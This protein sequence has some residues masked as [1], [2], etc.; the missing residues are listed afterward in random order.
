MT[1]LLLGLAGPDGLDVQLDVFHGDRH[2]THL[3]QVTPAADGTWVRKLT[4][5]VEGVEGAL[6]TAENVLNLTLDRTKDAVEQG[7]GLTG[8]GPVSANYRKP[9]PPGCTPFEN[10]GFRDEKQV[11][12]TTIAHNGV[13]ASVEYTREATAETSVGGSLNGGL[14]SSM[15]S[16]SRTMGVKAAFLKQ[17]AK[18]KKTLSMEYPIEVRH[19]VLRRSCARD[20]RGKEDVLF[21]TSPLGGTGGGRPVPSRYRGWKCGVDDPRAADAGFD[22]VETTNARAAVYNAAFDLEVL[23]GLNFVGSSQSGYSKSVSI[24]Y[25]FDPERGGYWCGLTDKPAFSSRVQAF[26]Q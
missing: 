13:T 4:G 19:I 1:E 23:P 14:F 9:V 8:A 17:F 5:L 24:K 7:L 21:I 25:T 16:R 15:G 11:V 10:V 18:P 26:G 20:F 12:A 2:Y 6:E 22:F 3:S